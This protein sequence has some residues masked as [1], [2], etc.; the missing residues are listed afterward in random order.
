MN[1]FS[2]RGRYQIANKSPGE[3]GR[4]QSLIPYIHVF[5]TQ[6]DLDVDS[7]HTYIW[8]RYL[9]ARPKTKNKKVT[10]CKGNSFC[11]KKILW[12]CETIFFIINHLTLKVKWLLP[13]KQK[14][15]NFSRCN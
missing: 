4:P 2:N 9:W 12:F 5:T 7:K 6:V 13:K 15:I 14:M 11:E 10:Y 8:D 1:K 3:G